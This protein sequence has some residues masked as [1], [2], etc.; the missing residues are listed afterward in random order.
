[1]EL[2]K[3]WYTANVTMIFQSL[4]DTI[5][6]TVETTSETVLKPLFVLHRSLSNI[7]NVRIDSYC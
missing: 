3:L 4:E 2:S 5:D 6:M 1:M 7:R